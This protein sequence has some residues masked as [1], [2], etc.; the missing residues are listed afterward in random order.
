MGFTDLRD[1]GSDAHQ[2]L[3]SIDVP[4]KDS[5]LLKSR[6][7]GIPCRRKA[8]FMLYLS[9]CIGQLCR[10]W[11]DLYSKN[12]DLQGSCKSVLSD[13]QGGQWEHATEGIHSA[14]LSL[15]TTICAALVV[16]E[17]AFTLQHL[18]LTQTGKDCP[19]QQPHSIWST[20]E[21]ALVWFSQFVWNMFSDTGPEF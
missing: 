17:K 11:R 12:S 9:L 1:D 10:A 15:S 8:Y 4:R 2:H 7:T 19:E 20:M 6:A 18:L 14:R 16:L 21:L 13:R 5:T 3:W